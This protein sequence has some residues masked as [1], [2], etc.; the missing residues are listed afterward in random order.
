[1]R[2][3]MKIRKIIPITGLKRPII[4]HTIAAPN[5]PEVFA[6]LTERVLVLIYGLTAALPCVSS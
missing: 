2:D 1:M 6:V 3:L 5:S 4:K